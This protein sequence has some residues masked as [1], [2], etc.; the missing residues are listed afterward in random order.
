MSHQDPRED[1]RMIIEDL[2]RARAQRYY[3][4]R[5]V[6]RTVAGAPSARRGG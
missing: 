3:R 1:A 6:T 4:P 2:V 5:L